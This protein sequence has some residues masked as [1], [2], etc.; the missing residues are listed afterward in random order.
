M[1][2]KKNFTSLCGINTPIL[3][4]FHVVVEADI[5]ATHTG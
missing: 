3:L 1:E 5:P 4:V 2:E